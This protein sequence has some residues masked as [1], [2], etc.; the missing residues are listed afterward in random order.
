MSVK[1]VFFDVQDY[2]KSTLLAGTPDNCEFILIESPFQDALDANIEKVRDAEIISVFTSSRV[3]S[4]L[5]D[6]LPELKL[7]T[8]RSTGYSHIDREYCK[9]RGIAVV[10]VPRYGECTV[11]EY[12]FALLLNVARKVSQ[13]YNELREGKIDLHMYK[14]IDL[15]GKTIGIIGTGAIG[16]YTAKIAYGFG[17]KILSYDLFPKEELKDKYE[18]EYVELD[19]LLKSSDIISLHAP[20]TKENFHMINDAAF[21]KMK[22]GV[23]IVNTARGEIM[24]TKALYKALKSGKVSGAGLDVVEC[25]EILANEELYLTKTECIKQDCLEKTLINHRLLDMPNVII[26]PH[27]A[28]DSVEAIER[29]LET[30]IGN[31]NSY[32]CGN[33]VNTV[34]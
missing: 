28:F 15:A 34:I 33:I 24:D 22:D 10:N 16:T 4:T 1:V 9:E 5:L 12:T 29:I 18:A 23:I 30:T 20:S 2:E 6:K 25:E 8:T 31:I 27:I 13:A 19:E 32:L 3:T 11:A 17:M 21:D 26:T 7:V 14:G